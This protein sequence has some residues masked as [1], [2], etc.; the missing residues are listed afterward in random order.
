M[1]QYHKFLF[2]CL[3]V[4]KQTAQQRVRKN[5]SCLEPC[6]RQLVSTLDQ[7][8]KNINACI[9]M[10][11]SYLQIILSCTIS[12]Q[13]ALSDELDNKPFLR[14]HHSQPSSYL[15]SSN[16]YGSFQDAYIPFPRTSGAKFCSVGQYNF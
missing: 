8:S 16:I 11:H 12:L 6:L 5:K 14:L 13:I 1:P 4:L 3:K 2:C 7:V 9:V 15:E 10:N